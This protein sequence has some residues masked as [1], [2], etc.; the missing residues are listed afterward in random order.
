MIDFVPLTEI[1]DDDV[2]TEQVE[3]LARR[4]YWAG[5]YCL[6]KD[7]LEVGCGAGQGVGDLASV[8]KSVRAGDCSATL[9]NIAREH[10]GAR[11]AFEQFDA[12]RLPCADDA[13]DVVVIFEALYYIPEIEMFFSECRRVLR[14]EG[15]LLIASA[16]KDLFDFN[17]SPHSSR[18]LGVMELGE[19]L[20]RH[21]FAPR[22]S[23]MRP[24]WKRRRASSSF[25]PL[26]PSRPG[27]VLFPH[28]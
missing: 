14:H 19:E 20:G 7:V 8:A 23:A 18:Y 13:F 2:S 17:A 9:L 11:F 28:P 25:V 3:R 24:W 15:A 1:S 21:G 6:G 5:E 4:Y 10:Y 27:L 22:F 26:R 12:G 16:N